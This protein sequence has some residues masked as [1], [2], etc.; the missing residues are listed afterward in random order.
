MSAVEAMAAGVPMVAR[1]VL[2]YRQLIKDGRS[3]LL[4]SGASEFAD[5]CVRLLRDP[6]A[7]RTLGRTAQAAARDYDWPRIA[8]IF[9]DQIESVLAGGLS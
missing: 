5:C 9:L 3:G 4:A 8:D 1:D 7:A 2:T 6:E